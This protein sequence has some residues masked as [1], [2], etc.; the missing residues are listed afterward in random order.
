VSVCSGRAGPEPLHHRSRGGG[1]HGWK[2][3]RFAA[4]GSPGVGGT[5]LGPEGTAPLGLVSLRF[6][7][8]TRPYTARTGSCGVWWWPP[9]GL[10]FGGVFVNWIVDASI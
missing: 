8:Q 1:A 2:L 5:L 9:W 4:S 10:G 7:V 6:R 3:Q